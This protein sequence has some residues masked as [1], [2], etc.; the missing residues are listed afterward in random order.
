MIVQ[1]L[2]DKLYSL[3]KDAEVELTDKCY[4]A[5]DVIFCEHDNVV[6]ISALKARHEGEIIVPE[7]M[8]Y[9]TFAEEWKKHN[10]KIFVIPRDYM[11]SIEDSINSGK[12]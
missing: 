10:G 3:P 11:G 5:D 9:D 2:I 1:E 6:I 12:E 8:D 4:Y 7:D